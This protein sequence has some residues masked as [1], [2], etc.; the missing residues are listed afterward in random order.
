MLLDCNIM[1]LQKKAPRNAKVRAII[2]V[3]GARGWESFTMAMLSVFMFACGV[4]VVDQAIFYAQG[5]AKY[6]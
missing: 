5:P 2:G 3:A 4:K 6:C 1:F